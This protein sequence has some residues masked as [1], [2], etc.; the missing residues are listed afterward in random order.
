VNHQANSPRIVLLLLYL[1]FAAI[2]AKLFFLQIL[3][4]RQLNLQKQTFRISKENPTRGKII[5]F[6]GHTL[7]ANQD[8]YLLSIYKPNL[9]TSLDQITQKIIQVKPEFNENQSLINNFRQNDNQKW[10]TFPTKFSH[11]ETE[12]L[13]SIPGIEFEHKL[14]RYYPQSDSFSVIT[15]RLVVSNNKTT[16]LGGLEA[17]YHQALSGKTGFFYTYHDALGNTIFPQKSWRI[18][19]TDG[20]DLHTTIYSKIQYFARQTL[21]QGISKYNADSGSITIIEPK[22]G[23]IIAMVAIESTE[24]AKP[25]SVNPVIASTFEPGSVFKPLVVA[26]A[27]DSGSI[28]TDFICHQCHTPPVI[29]GNVINNWDN[30][31][32]PNSNLKDIIK[33]SDNIGMTSIIQQIGLKKFLAYYDRLELSRKTGIDLQGESR[34]A[35]KDYWSDIDLA[36]AS[37]GQGFAVTQLK[38]VQVFNAIANEGLIVQPY[39]VDYLA[40]LNT[41]SHS[42]HT[43]SK[44]VFSQN[45]TQEVKSILQY[46]VDNSVLA[47]IKPSDLEV[48]AKSGTAQVAIGGKYTDSSTVASYVGFYPCQNPLFTM[49]VTLNNPKSSPWGSSTA[50]PIWFEI[51]S[52]IRFLL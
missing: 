21:V 34:S 40:N 30:Q 45:S 37:F 14:D 10:I 1:G 7:A 35:K 50:A 6:D 33:N 36:A 9:K 3:S 39:L 26:M 4:D 22:S 13:Q 23:K 42:K 31:V 52:R 51:A 44:R 43:P 20:Y 16:A 12:T 38:M 5:S 25:V 46:S 2:T 18:N 27:L 24:S 32:H 48:C 29:N 17:Y 49:I 15:G 11:Q 47:Q 19:K 41:V 8:I 28:T